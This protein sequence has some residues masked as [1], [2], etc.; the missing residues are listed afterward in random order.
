MVIILMGVASSG[1][2]TIGQLLAQQLDWPFFDA[3][4]FHP[5]ANIAKMSQGI[6]LTDE[7]RWPWL[8]AIHRKSEELLAA[9]QSGVITCSALKQIYRDRL[10]GEGVQFIYLKGTPEILIQRIRA[11]TDHFM[12]PEMLASQLAALE[13]PTGALIVDISP[14]PDDIVTTIRAALKL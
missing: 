7:D 8:A 9:D 4:E 2:T 6:A 1:K 11:R 14:E 10:T 3:D 13:E 5:P 12:R